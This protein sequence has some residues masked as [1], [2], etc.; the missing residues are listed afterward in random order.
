MSRPHEFDDARQPRRGASMN[1][2]TPISL[3]EATLEQQASQARADGHASAMRSAQFDMFKRIG[4]PGRRF[5]PWHFTDLRAAM[6]SA[7]P[8]FR[9]A[10]ASVSDARLS[11][12]ARGAIKLVL[13][14]GFLRSDL[15]N[16]G[17]LP[18]GA[19]L[20]TLSEALASGDED[21]IAALAPVD[22]TDDPI[23]ALN[24]ALMTG[25]FVLDL[26]A[27]L[28][29][30]RPIEV[31]RLYT[32]SS[33]SS[34]IFSRSA[35]RLGAGARLR[36]F[37]REA[38]DG[39]PGSRHIHSTLVATL[40][41]GAQMEATWAAASS[42]AAL[43]VESV[44]MVLGAR[45]CVRS[46]SLISQAPF[47]RRQAF[48]RFD[49]PDADAS[50]MGLS[51]LRGAERADNTLVL[52]H[53]APNCRSRELFKH[54]VDDE[55]VGVFQ[56]KVVVAPGAQKTDGSMTSRA[57][58]LSDRAGMDNKPELEIFADDVAC[59][60][61]AV[62]GELDEELLFF[63]MSRGLP[64]AEAESM[65]LEAFAAEVFDGESDEALRDDLLGRVRSWLARR[66]E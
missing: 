33:Q 23:A 5:E 29:L 2:T 8:V 31:L 4:V 65:L 56:G 16:V 62:C 35:I 21:L 48:V 22:V 32:A 46:T 59:G 49:G 53:R 30:E 12:V 3:V 9:D 7:L 60:H 11:T 63:V 18:E 24:G 66:P 55:A 61:G 37:E 27:G 6:R 20:L 54:I 52:T 25:G 19:R 1:A 10:A 45:A 50:F 40:G 13:V 26:Q 42:S 58:L 28:R 43:Q 51:L 15:S 34:A 57:I 14:D 47:L 41:E 36:L 38:G 39:A 44:L 64:R 17:D